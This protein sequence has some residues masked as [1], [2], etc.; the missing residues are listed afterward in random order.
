MKRRENWRHQYE[1]MLS[2]I[3]QYQ[4]R[5]K[6]YLENYN[7]RSMQRRREKPAFERRTAWTTE[8]QTAADGGVRISAG[9]KAKDRRRHRGSKIRRWPGRP[10]RR[11]AAAR[12]KWRC[13]VGM[14]AMKTNW[15]AAKE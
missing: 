11:T 1:T 4:R 2:A 10:G 13:G 3:W 5:V 9:E 6:K 7:Q 14:K 8:G 15:L 12:R